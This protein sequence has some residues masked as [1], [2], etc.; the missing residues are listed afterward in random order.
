MRR[1]FLL[2]L[3]LALANSV[4]VVAQSKSDE[5]NTLASAA[6]VVAEELQQRANCDVGRSMQVGIWPLDSQS[7][8]ITK[9]TAT[10]IYQMVLVDLIAAKPA[11][12]TFFGRRRG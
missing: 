6:R 10:Q 11:C 4:G 1:H 3:F 2:I 12:V 9:E 5:I 8:P 7:L